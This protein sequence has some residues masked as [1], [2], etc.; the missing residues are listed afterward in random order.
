MFQ[1]LGP[2]GY[3][4]DRSSSR[5]SRA[6]RGVRRC[7]RPDEAGQHEGAVGER[8]VA[9]RGPH[10]LGGVVRREV[11][12]GPAAGLAVLGER[13]DGAAMLVEV[14]A[15]ELRRSGVEG[16]REALVRTA[17]VATAAAS[18]P[19]ATENR[20]LSSRRK[21]TV[22]ELPSILG[23]DS[24]RS[25]A[26]KAEAIFSWP[27]AET[28]VDTPLSSWATLTFWSAEKNRRQPS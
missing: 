13:V 11:G 25:N 2:N 7:A 12:V 6:G 1:P 23:S 20:T 24:A 16:S 3:D 21:N 27:A 28:A 15:V 26:R 8:R 22:S 14:G 4:S 10:G 5:L 18:A 17:V 9:I 19:W